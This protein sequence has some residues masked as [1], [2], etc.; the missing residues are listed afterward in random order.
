MID[1]KE[2]NRL[3]QANFY[4]K[5]KDRI[6]EKRRLKRQEKKA[7]VEPVVESVVEPLHVDIKQT[8]KSSVINLE[9]LIKG[10]KNLKDVGIIKTTGTMGLYSANARQISKLI[11]CEDF[12]TCFKKTKEVIDKIDNSTYSINQIKSLYQFIVFIMDKLQLKYTPKVFTIYKDKF[13]AYKLKSKKYTEEKTTDEIIS[14]SEYLKKIESHFGKDSKM[15]NL[16]SL[17]GID[18]TFRDNFQLEIVS[19]VKDTKDKT[20]NYFV[21]NIKGHCFLIINNYK[22]ATYGEQKIKLNKNLS[23]Q[24]ETYI[25]KEGLKVGDYLFGN[26]KLGTYISK[27]N[28]EI[29]IKGGIDLLRKMKYSEANINGLTE[30]QQ[31]E[32]AKKFQHT[33]NAQIN[34]ARI[35]QDNKV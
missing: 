1:S 15:Y 35:I 17:Y 12:N 24:I 10:L 31:V 14:F 20:K 7:V 22:T 9:E 11:Q 21:K 34:Y 18:N 8:K 26:K 4:S 25:E 30:E 33:P 3:K 5:N 2:K 32:L 16:I 13:D 23:N 27:N 19:F 6:N 28:L 29:G